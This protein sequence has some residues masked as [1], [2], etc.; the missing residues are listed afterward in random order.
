MEASPIIIDL[1]FLHSFYEMCVNDM[2]Q[3]RNLSNFTVVGIDVTHLDEVGFEYLS[4]KS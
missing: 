2:V 4:I 1:N 3:T